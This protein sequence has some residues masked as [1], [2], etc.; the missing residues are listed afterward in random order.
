MIDECLHCRKINESEKTEC[1]ETFPPIKKSKFIKRVLFLSQ[2]FF[3]DR[4]SK[5]TT[6]VYSLKYK[7]MCS[8]NQGILDDPQN[9][10]NK[11]NFAKHDPVKAHNYIECLCKRIDGAAVWVFVFFFCTKSH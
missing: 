8:I 5:F 9:E 2:F 3:I 4:Q 11:I 10:G 1:R 7:L 6:N